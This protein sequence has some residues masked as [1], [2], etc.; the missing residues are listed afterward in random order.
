M[1]RNSTSLI[2]LGPLRL[3]ISPWASLTPYGFKGIGP[4]LSPLPNAHAYSCSKHFLITLVP[5]EGSAVTYMLFVPDI[6][7]SGLVSLSVMLQVTNSYLFRGSV[8]ELIY[9]TVLPFSVSVTSSVVLII[10]FLMLALGLLCFFSYF[11]KVEA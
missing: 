2:E 8:F 5:S 4:F 1:T 10:S 7:N 3:S 9:F 6:G 11:L